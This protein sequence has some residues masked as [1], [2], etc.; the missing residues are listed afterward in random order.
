MSERFQP[1]PELP[2][3]R[4]ASIDPKH[5]YARGGYDS[6]NSGPEYNP[7]LEVSQPVVGLRVKPVSLE[8]PNQ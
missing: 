6:P 7:V 8:T 4:S 5:T 3:D 1:H 2:P